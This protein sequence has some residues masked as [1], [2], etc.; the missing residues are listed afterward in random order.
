MWQVETLA[1]QELKDRLLPVRSHADECHRHVHLLLDPRDVLTGSG[2]QIAAV[3]ASH[4]ARR[5]ALQ[6]MCCLDA[7]GPGAMP[8]VREVIADSREP[9]KTLSAAARLLEGAF[10]DRQACDELL[11]RHARHWEL[12]RLALVDR[13][14]L[15]LGAHE[16][17]AGAAPPKVLIT[18][19]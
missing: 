4:R 7:Q 15:R 13:N 3:N 2:R 5:L 11:V 9:F 10:A 17:R 18:E 14:I 6:G 19:E 8:L 1:S 16:L 12:S